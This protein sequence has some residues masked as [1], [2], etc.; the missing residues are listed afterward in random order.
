MISDNV[1]K[2]QF[3]HCRKFYSPVLVRSLLGNIK[4]IVQMRKLKLR[5]V[6]E[7]LKKRVRIVVK[8]PILL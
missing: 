2:D 5:E 7:S 4:P 6:K 8:S 3:H 1:A